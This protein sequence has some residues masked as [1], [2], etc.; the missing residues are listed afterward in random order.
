MSDHICT[1]ESLVAGGIKLKL[2]NCPYCCHTGDQTAG[3]AGV[4]CH[5]CRNLVTGDE[6]MGDFAKWRRERF[7]MTRKQIG[8]LIGKS[9][10]TIKGYE[11]KKCTHEYSNLTIELLAK[12]ILKERRERCKID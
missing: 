3:Y 8:K 2:A 6:F 9:P 10:H 4:L 12:S 7:G 1:A 11:F 5:N